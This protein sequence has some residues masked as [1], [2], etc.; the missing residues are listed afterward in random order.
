ME[1]SVKRKQADILDDDDDD[2]VV[3]IHD[4]PTTKTTSPTTKKSV[5]PSA[6]SPRSPK[7]QKCKYGSKC[8]RTN[9]S[10]LAEFAH[11]NDQDDEPKLLDANK[12]IKLS[13]AIESLS[14][15]RIYL[16]KVHRVPNSIVINQDI[17]LS[18]KDILALDELDFVDSAQFNY[19]HDVEW[20]RDQYPVRNR[21]K[22]MT[23]VHASRSSDELGP[24]SDF[25]NIKVVKVDLTLLKIIFLNLDFYML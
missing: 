22:P 14:S 5:P 24:V 4:S 8:Y 16:T 19:M 11:G 1:K 15:R 9:P 18:L 7:R 2:D 21:D 25:P 13:S 20:L 3:V 17:A 23:L 10:H 12:Q 6:T